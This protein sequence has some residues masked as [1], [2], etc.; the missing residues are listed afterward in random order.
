MSKTR[1]PPEQFWWLRQRRSADTMC[2]VNKHVVTKLP[3]LGAST[4]QA[5]PC[6]SEQ[7]TR[8]NRGCRSGYYLTKA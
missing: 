4:K 8:L 2:E 1:A 6:G 3:E 5:Q 7:E